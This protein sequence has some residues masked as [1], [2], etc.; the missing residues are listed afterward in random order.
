M[1][2]VIRK[3]LSSLPRPVLTGSRFAAPKWISM[4]RIGNCAL[5]DE[6]RKYPVNDIPNSWTFLTSITPEIQ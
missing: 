3:K 5:P 2:K 4:S 6:T 1:V